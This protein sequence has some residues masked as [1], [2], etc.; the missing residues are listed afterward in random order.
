MVPCISFSQ[1][2][3]EMT[4]RLRSDDAVM[5]TKGVSIRSTNKQHTLSLIFRTREYERATHSLS[6]LDVILPLR[7]LLHRLFM[8]KFYPGSSTALQT[9]SRKC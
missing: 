3:L 6:D 7:H 8:A 5:V 1:R 2:T 4:L 9:C